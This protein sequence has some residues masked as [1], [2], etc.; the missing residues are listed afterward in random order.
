M[1]VLQDIQCAAAILSAAVVQDPRQREIAQAMFEL[2]YGVD[3]SNP[4]GAAGV[5]FATIAAR[6]GVTR[7]WVHT[8]V[9]Q[10][11]DRAHE[12]HSTMRC[13]SIEVRRRITE[14][15]VLSKDDPI[16]GGVDL[17]DARR[18]YTDMFAEAPKKA[19]NTLR[20]TA[21]QFD[22]LADIGGFRGGP[23]VA[24]ARLVLV[25]GLRLAEASRNVGAQP[26]AVHNART[27]IL[28]IHD[29]IVG[30]YAAPG[31]T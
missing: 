5:S 9:H 2:R 28:R 31:E 4:A 24:G 1:T 13:A 19:S 25:D 16:L 15:P 30:A 27:R 17:S 8:L 22:C 29:K 23:G 11:L 6:F 26:Q 21:K 7:Q 10:M 12:T 18:F 20:L 14:N 3:V